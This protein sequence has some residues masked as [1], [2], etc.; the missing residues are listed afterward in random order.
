MTFPSQQ[1][2]DNQTHGTGHKAM[3][4]AN[5]TELFISLDSR[6]IATDCCVLYEFGIRDARRRHTS[7]FCARTAEYPG[8]KLSTL[9]AAEQATPS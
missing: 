1:H 5:G 7:A 4:T 9:A 3:V 2:L 6:A 8:T